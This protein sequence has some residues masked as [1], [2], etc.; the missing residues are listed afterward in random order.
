MS[1]ILP[2]DYFAAQDRLC[3]WFEDLKQA[4][5]CSENADLGAVLRKAEAMGRKIDA[6]EEQQAIVARHYNYESWGYI[7]RTAMNGSEEEAIVVETPRECLEVPR[8]W[9][10]GEGKPDYSKAKKQLPTT[11]KLLRKGLVFIEVR[12]PEEGDEWADESRQN[13]IKA[14]VESGSPKEVER[15]IWRFINGVDEEDDPSETWVPIAEEAAAE[16][17]KAND[18]P[19][20]AVEQLLAYAEEAEV[21][22]T[23]Q[24]LAFMEESESVAKRFFDYL[25]TACLYKQSRVSREEVE[26]T[27]ALVERA[28]SCWGCYDPTDNPSG[29]Y[30]EV[31]AENPLHPSWTKRVYEP[32]ISVEQIDAACRVVYKMEEE[33]KERTITH[34]EMEEAVREAVKQPEAGQ[35]LT[36]T[37]K[38]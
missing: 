24:A 35:A 23:K 27:S 9:C 12:R 6:Y 28:L 22:I 31:S 18:L 14:F 1:K 7:L 33:A 32:S 25:L 17:E 37:E 15:E 4:I 16:L 19:T 11:Q 13:L 38:N 36:T 8:D 10:Y 20:T 34:N 21:E 2:S 29:C 30:K 5:G 26:K 3:E